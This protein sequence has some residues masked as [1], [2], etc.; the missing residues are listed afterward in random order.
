MIQINKA[1]VIFE[2]DNS[3]GIPTVSYDL[4]L[5]FRFHPEDCDSKVDLESLRAKIQELYEIIDENPKVLFDFEL[6]ALLATQCD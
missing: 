5:Y 6:E 2:G 4:D 1:S 3:V